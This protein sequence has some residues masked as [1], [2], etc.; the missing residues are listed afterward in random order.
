MAKQKNN[1]VTITLDKERHLH[2]TLNSL[3]LIEDLTG[4]SIDKI[5]DN[6]NMKLLKAIIYAGLKHEDSELTLE[7]VGEMI[8]FEDIEKVSKAIAEAFGGLK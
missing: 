4:V 6:M 2:F 1:M 8:G 5:G 7:S 3:E